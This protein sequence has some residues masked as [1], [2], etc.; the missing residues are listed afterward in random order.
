MA[1]AIADPSVPFGKTHA[2][3]YVAAAAQMP[4]KDF[5]AISQRQPLLM[6]Q[7]EAFENILKYYEIK[8]GYV[9][10]VK[11]FHFLGFNL[12]TSTYLPSVVS[13]FF[14]GCLLFVWLQKIFDVQFAALIT[15]VVA[16]SPFLIITARYSSPDM[17]CAAVS[18]AALFLI[19]E[20]SVSFGVV[21]FVFAIPIRPDVV[22]LYLLTILML[23]KSKKF[24]AKNSWM[25]GVAGII[26]TLRSLGNILPLQEFFFTTPSYSSSWS[27]AEMLSGYGQGLWGGLNSFVNSQ[28]SVFI[29]LATITLYLRTKAN[30]KITTDFWSLLLIGILATI[31]VRFLLHPVIEDRFQITPYLIII[32]ALCKTISHLTPLKS[33]LN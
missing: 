32:I 31:M 18:L 30:Y 4:S 26:V 11:I 17:L 12:V 15:L 2:E 7:P 8:P 1:L 13:Y 6:K 29:F 25:L 20:V 21:L 24:P 27:A 33:T 22:I 14:I 5:T 3:V 23:Y 9:L 10:I 19:S 16:A 28:T